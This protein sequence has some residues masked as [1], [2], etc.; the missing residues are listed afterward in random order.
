MKE[1]AKSPAFALVSSLEGSAPPRMDKL[2]IGCLALAGMIALYIPKVLDLFVAATFA[3]AVML[4]ARCLSVAEARQAVKWDILVAISAAFGIS[5]ALQA[6]GVA[7][8]IA[9][10]LGEGQCTVLMPWQLVVADP[11]NL[12]CNLCR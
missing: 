2:W 9:D 10:V 8:A 4:L 7:R 1:H 5:A 11:R 6:S 3:A 12:L